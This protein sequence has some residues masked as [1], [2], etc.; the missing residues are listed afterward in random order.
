MN[1]SGHRTR[2]HNVAV[3]EDAGYGRFVDVNGV[4]CIDMPGMCAMGVHYV[5]GSLVGDG[6][7]DALTYPAAYQARL[8]RSPTG[9]GL[10]I[11]TRPRVAGRG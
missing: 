6:K 8:P 11:D 1:L 4:A 9:I 10:V 7:G 2:Q 5:N 3:A